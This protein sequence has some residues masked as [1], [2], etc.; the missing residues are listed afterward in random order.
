MKTQIINARMIVTLLVL[1]IFV[2]P[3]Y[4][5]ST[6]QEADATGQG[7]MGLPDSI[8]GIVKGFPGQRRLFFRR[9]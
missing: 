5:Q 9:F 8:D 6:G 7:E 3:G 4:G 2:L 1:S